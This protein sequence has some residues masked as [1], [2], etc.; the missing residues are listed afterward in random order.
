MSVCRGING[1]GGPESSERG[2][3]EGQT[4]ARRPGFAAIRL[5]S[6]ATRGPLKQLADDVQHTCSERREEQWGKWI[7]KRAKGGSPR[8]SVTK[9]GDRSS[10]KRKSYSR[11]AKSKIA[12]KP[13]ESRRNV[14]RPKGRG[15]NGGQK[16]P[17]G[18]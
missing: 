9:P 17:A 18:N 7:E 3:D 5:S 16:R 2:V 13:R 15:R 14:L 8:A 1:A 12:R 6:W 4:K 10:F 11:N